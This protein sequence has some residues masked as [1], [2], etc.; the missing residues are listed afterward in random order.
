MLAEIKKL[1]DAQS[2]TNLSINNLGERV[3]AIEADLNSMEESSEGSPRGVEASGKTTLDISKVNSRCDGTKNRLR[4][5]PSYYSLVLPTHQLKLGDNSEAT[6]LN[7]CEQRLGIQL[8]PNIDRTHH[9]G[10]FVADKNRLRI[11]NLLR[12]KNKQSILSFGYKL[13]DSEYAVRRLV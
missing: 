2:T 3:T 4:A 13:K 6:V 9:L 11:V 7:F 1:Q 10:K 5:G 8:D 12:F